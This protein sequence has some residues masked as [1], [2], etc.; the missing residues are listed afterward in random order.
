MRCKL[1][2]LCLLAVL[3]AFV[4]LAPAR[5]M[6][7]DGVP[8]ITLAEFKA[9]LASPSP[10][11]IIDV[12]AGVDTKIRGAHVIPLGEIEARLHEIPRDRPIV[13]YCS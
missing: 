8:R 1:F 9:L 4:P 10:P 2:S 13:T 11:F 3:G 6:Q 5:A 12:R 7:S